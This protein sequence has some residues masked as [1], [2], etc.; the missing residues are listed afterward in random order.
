MTEHKLW[1]V[2]GTTC[3][4][5][6]PSSPGPPLSTHLFPGGTFLSD[7]PCPQRVLF[8]GH[9]KPALSLRGTLEGLLDLRDPPRRWAGTRLCLPDLPAGISLCLLPRLLSS[10]K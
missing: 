5:P 8:K 3:L 2:L 1:P 6:A 9:L 10:R 7:L 4:K